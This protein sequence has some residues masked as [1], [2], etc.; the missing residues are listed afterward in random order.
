MRD[1]NAYA[2]INRRESEDE[3]EIDSQ[4]VDHRTNLWSKTNPVRVRNEEW[5][6]YKKRRKEQVWKWEQ[7][8][9]VELL[10]IDRQRDKEKSNFLTS[11]VK[12]SNLTEVRRD[13][14]DIHKSLIARHLVC[15]SVNVLTRKITR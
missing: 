8:D 1:V 3:E 2:Q 10:A 7:T 9:R 5:K 15:H 11:D 6:N 4:I 14:N 13:G 12:V